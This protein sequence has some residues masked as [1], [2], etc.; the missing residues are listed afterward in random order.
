MTE[1]ERVNKLKETLK[2]LDLRLETSYDGD[3]GTEFINIIN[4]DG[5]EVIEQH[6]FILE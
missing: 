6:K 3:K 1:S 4:K 2:E 5:F